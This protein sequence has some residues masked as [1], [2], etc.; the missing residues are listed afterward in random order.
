MNREFAQREYQALVKYL[1]QLK[2]VEQEQEEEA[3]E[4]ETE[5][6]NE[7]SSETQSVPDENNQ[8]EAG[9]VDSE[10]DEEEGDEVE[11]LLEIYEKYMKKNEKI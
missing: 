9:E 7:S 10:T 3:G 1:F 5:A 2:K 4:V 11:V 8:E 6:M